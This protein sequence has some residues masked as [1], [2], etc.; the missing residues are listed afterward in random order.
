MTA[1]AVLNQLDL[2]F[3]TMALK[4]A[5]IHLKNI[6][7]GKWENRACLLKKSVLIT[8]EKFFN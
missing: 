2:R 4:F 6:G 3:R 7:F 1:A 8:S 5:F